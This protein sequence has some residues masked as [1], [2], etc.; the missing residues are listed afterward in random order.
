M[1]SNTLPTRGLL[2]LVNPRYSRNPCSSA[3]RHALTPAL[4]LPTLAAATPPS[5]QVRFHDENLTWGQPPMRPVPEVVGIT[6]HTAFAG[7]AYELARRYRAMGSKVVLGGLHVTALPQEAALHADVVV[8]GEGAGLWPAVLEGLRSKTLPSG[9]ILHGSGRHP[10]YADQAWPR[11]DILPRGAFLTQAS[12]VATRG[13]T[14]RCGY[15]YLSTRG[16]HSPYQ[17]RPVADVMAEID[18]LAE[19]YVV[20][21]DNN[22]MADP[23]YGA[24]LCRALHA[25]R[26]LWSA[27]V[28]VDVAR[29]PNLVRQMAASGCHGV[30]VG[31]ET[32][33]DDTLHEQRKRT[34]APSQ[35]MQAVKLLRDHHI[36]VNGSFVFGF[37][38]DGPD[39]F[40]RTLAFIV[41]QRLACAT[42]HILTPYPGTPLFEKL[43]REGRILTHDWSRYDTAHVV[44]QPRGM[45]PIQLQQGYRKAYQD[46]YRWG[47]VFA[48]RPEGGALRTASYLAVTALYKKWDWVWRGL[49]PLRLTHAVWH[50]VIEM[51]RRM[52]LRARIPFPAKE[53]AGSHVGSLSRRSS[54]GLS[55]VA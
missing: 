53:E 41:E 21:T 14:Q 20:F 10:H 11:R 28:T 12:I 15:C 24:E 27:A 5:W 18:S 6:V 44:F 33:E 46:L 7:R 17:K 31:L 50:P 45:T 36:E 35:Y 19:R 42:F 25:R 4:G 26:L 9:S 8:T 34:L 23:E 32:L 39:V 55:L 38:A 16:L 1:V 3:G 52:S 29:Y 43:E 2:L 30:F 47:T 51:R 49:V 40:D 22:L 37:D 54:P 48:R 13:C